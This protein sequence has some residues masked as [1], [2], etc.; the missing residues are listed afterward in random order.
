MGVPAARADGRAVVERMKRMPTDDGCFG[1]GRI[2]ED[3]RALHPVYLFRAKK[4]SEN[5]QP[6]D[7]AE[8]VATTPADE[9]WRPISEGDCPLV[10]S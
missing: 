8:L 10:K 5:K 6:W 1:P 3:G 9:A 4:P 7:V 2:R